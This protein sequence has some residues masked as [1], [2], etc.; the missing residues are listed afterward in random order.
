MAGGCFGAPALELLVPEQDPRVEFPA[1]PVVLWDPRPLHT[2]PAGQVCPPAAL[3]SPSATVSPSGSC[4]ARCPRCCVAGG[5]VSSS[6]L[7]TL[8]FRRTDQSTKSEQ[9]NS[10][11]KQA[12][13]LGPLVG[14][15]C[16]G[17][18]GSPP[19]D[20]TRPSVS[21]PSGCLNP[22]VLKC[23]TC[24]VEVHASLEHCLHPSLAQWEFSR[25]VWGRGGEHP[26]HAH[27]TI[28]PG[29]AKAV[30]GGTRSSIGSRWICKRITLS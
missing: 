2:W 18:A 7:S 26:V 22:R 8:A 11:R 28:W 19:V 14:M 27:R 4:T 16:T 23:L 25:G 13:L 6:L 1:G 10:A 20:V 5:P 29:P 3:P 12:V 24:H 30:V 15:E 21:S 9:Q 17:V